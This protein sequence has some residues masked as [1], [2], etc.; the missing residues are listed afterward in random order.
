MKDQPLP[1]A[2]QVREWMKLGFP[3]V[4]ME[5]TSIFLETW[6]PGRD[7]KIRISMPLLDQDPKT[8]RKYR[9]EIGEI[10]TW[11]IQESIEGREKPMLDLFFGIKKSGIFDA[12][13]NKL[14]ANEINSESDIAY[15]LNLAFKLMSIVY[16]NIT[17]PDYYQELVK[18][19]EITKN[20]YPM[21][22]V[23]PKDDVNTWLRA[24]LTVL[25]N[26]LNKISNN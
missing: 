10:R 23:Y 17:E 1:I 24:N 20:I 4:Q 6:L 11:L 19:G 18:W 7:D 5:S 22:D 14:R 2:D 13:R 12:D 26:F 21:L 9:S 16:M 25:S 3:T 8:V 15:I